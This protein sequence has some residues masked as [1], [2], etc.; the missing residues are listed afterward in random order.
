MLAVNGGVRDLAGIIVE[1][2]FGVARARLQPSELAAP[3]S[4]RGIQF[5]KEDSLA[6]DLL[7]GNI[8]R[9]APYMDMISWKILSMVPRETGLY[10][11]SRQHAGDQSLFCAQ[12]LLPL[13]QVAQQQAHH[14]QV[15][16][17]HEQAL[18]LEFSDIDL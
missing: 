16:R 5:S 3:I 9:D 2:D 15:D 1:I 13:R 14:D 4:L 11:Y 7:G 8:T 10:A 18:R 6:V 17:Q 12:L